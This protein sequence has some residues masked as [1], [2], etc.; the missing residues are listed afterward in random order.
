[1]EVGVSSNYAVIRTAITK[2]QQVVATYKGKR[3]EMCPHV[4]GHKNGREQALVFQ[5]GGE[6]SRPLPPR[7]Q[8]RCL[9]V[10]ELDSIQLLDG[11][12]HSGDGHSRRQ[13]CVDVV[14]LEVGG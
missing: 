5:F 6:S 14:D 1:L 8:W 7:G 12:W 2:R 3:R 11:E 9:A 13:S 4:I 10:A